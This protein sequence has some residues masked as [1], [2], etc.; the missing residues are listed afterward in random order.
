MKDT[1][2]F[3][4]RYLRDGIFIEQ[5][6]DVP[7]TQLDFELEEVQFISTIQGNVQLL[8]HGDADVYVIAEV[9][10]DIEM[11]CGKCLELF[12]SDINA[13]FQIQYT[14]RNNS[15]QIEPDEIDGGERYYDGETLDISE[16]TRK[17]IIIHIPIWPICSQLCEG[18]CYHCG[19]NLNEEKCLCEKTDDD[20]IDTSKVNSPFA[21]LARML[22]SAK[23][24][25]ESKT[26]KHKENIP[27]N[28]TSKTENV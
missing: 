24:D 7:V 16:E 20:E 18:L 5:E 27:K 4:V 2:V 19:T 8:R 17:E 21:D 15:D 6:V 25:G 11:Q 14:P 1:L 13:S 23:M 10:T 3:D 12:R 22:E 26:N 28:G 9:S